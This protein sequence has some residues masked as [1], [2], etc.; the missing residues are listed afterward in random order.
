MWT[1]LAAKGNTRKDG[2]GE[3]RLNLENNT[4]VCLGINRMVLTWRGLQGSYNYSLWYS[5]IVEACIIFHT[6]CAI[7]V[8][9]HATSFKSRWFEYE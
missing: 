8:I 2:I 1:V 5:I 4:K 7:Q 6:V 9:Q 3:Y